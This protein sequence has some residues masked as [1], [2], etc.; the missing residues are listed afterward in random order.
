MGE[1]T[2][3][4]LISEYGSLDGVYENIENIGGKLC[5]K[6]TDGKNSAYLSYTLATI[7]TACDLTISLADM[8]V[9]KVFSP[10][11]KAEFVALEFKSLYQ[12]T[13][14]FES[15][16]GDAPKDAAKNTAKN[17]TTFFMVAPCLLYLS[18]GLPLR[19]LQK[20]SISVPRRSIVR[21]VFAEFIFLSVIF[22]NDKDIAPQ[23]SRS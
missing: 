7:D 12:K 21:S 19:T 22:E 9:P 2:A 18:K 17:E 5:E 15:P 23:R 10:E 4:T 11:V 20:F 8:R 3:K 13:D 14:L 16:A 1:K 6:L